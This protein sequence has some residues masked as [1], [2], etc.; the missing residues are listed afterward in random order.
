VKFVNNSIRSKDSIMIIDS[1]QRH[2]ST[3]RII[4]FSKNEL[5][6]EGGTHL[7][8]NLCKMQHLEQLKLSGCNVTDRGVMAIV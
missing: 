1:F 3:L 4:D 5:G 7:A 6:V 2:M 8:Q